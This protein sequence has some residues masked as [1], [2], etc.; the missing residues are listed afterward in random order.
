MN[1]NI[2]ITLLTVG[3][4]FLGFIAWSQNNYNE[5][6]MGHKNLTTTD[7]YTT[8]DRLANSKALDLVPVLRKKGIV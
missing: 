5:S 4:L 8:V 1:K 7:R 2:I 3:F 6:D